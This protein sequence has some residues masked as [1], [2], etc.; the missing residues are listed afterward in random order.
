MSKMHRWLVG[1]AMLAL[2][3]CVSTPAQVKPHVRPVGDA[4]EAGN[5]DDADVKRVLDGVRMIQ[6]GHIQAAIDGPFD[7]VVE[8]YETRYAGSREKIF[9]ARGTADALLYAATALSAKPPLSAQVIGPA[10]AMAYWGRGYAYNEM[11][12]YDNAIVEL[13]KA[14]ALAPDDAQYNIE[15]AYAYQQKRQWQTSLELFKTAEAFVEMTVPAPEVANITCKALRGQG[16]DLVEMHQY[17]DARAA[18]NACLKQIPDEPRS[19]GE[20]KYIDQVEARKPVGF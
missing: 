15:L 3:G 19:L 16:Y 9:S 6:A 17:D 18:Y 20:L 10:W 8:R 5:R 13:R 11:A 2:A 14:L 7:E 12:R 1:G 4:T